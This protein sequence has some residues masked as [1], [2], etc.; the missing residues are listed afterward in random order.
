MSSRKITFAGRVAALETSDEIVMR[1]LRG[2]E[3][4]GLSYQ[5]R[6]LRGVLSEAINV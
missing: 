3:S 5:T 1:P 6:A 4:T 2:R